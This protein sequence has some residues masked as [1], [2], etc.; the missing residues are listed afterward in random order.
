MLANRFRSHQHAVMKAG[1][2]FHGGAESTSRGARRY[3]S[4]TAIVGRTVEGAVR[5]ARGLELENYLRYVF[6]SQGLLLLSM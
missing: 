5:C 3:Q 4:Q 6:P 1:R 2:K